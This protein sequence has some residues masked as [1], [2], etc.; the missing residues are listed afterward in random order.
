MKSAIIGIFVSPLLLIAQPNSVAWSNIGPSPAAVEAFAVDPQGTGTVFM[1]TIAGGVRKSVDNGSTWS[2][3]NSGLTTPIIQALA[4]DAS[5]PQTVYA[6]TLGGLF[7][8]GDGGIA[9]WQNI[10]ACDFRAIASVAADPKRPGV[11]YAAAFNN[12][13]N[14][15]I[16]KSTDGGVT[17]TTVFPTTAAIFNITI[18]P[19]NPDV[20]Y[21]P[22][23]GHGGYKSTDGGQHWSAMAALTPQAVW[24]LTLDP[25]NSQTV[26]A[27]TNQ[28]GIWK[29]TDAGNTWQQAGSPGAFPV[30]SLAVDTSAAHIVYAGTNGGGLWTSADGGATWKSTALASGMVLSLAVD[31]SGALYAGTNSAGAQVS[32]N[33]G[34]SWTLLNTG[35]EQVNKYGYGLWIDPRNNQ[36]ILVGDEDMYGLVW[37]QDGGA[38]WSAAGQGFTGRGSRGVAFDPTNSQRVYAGALNG[39]AFFREHRW[40]PH[41]VTAPLW[42][43]RRVR[44]DSGGGGSRRAPNLVYVGTQNEGFFKSTDYGR[45]GRL[46]ETGLSGGPTYLTVDPT[47]EWKIVRFHRNRILSVRG[48]RCNLD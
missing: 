16:R 36:K 47:R 42:F 17:W 46:P 37:S 1:G 5:G 44:R 28:D 3:L 32:H 33:H 25:S 2:T 31:S 30:Y 43:H 15:S 24:T 18:D 20:I 48:W 34:A 45:R 41:L 19:G 7:K 9:T 13:A 10:A 35:A 8:T 39:N 23:V 27:G 26:Y 38:T 21:A 4:M 6:G 11:V 29:S 14:G 12:L 40:G 22:T